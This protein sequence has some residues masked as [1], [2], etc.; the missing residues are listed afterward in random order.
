MTGNPIFHST[1]LLFSRPEK[2]LA[3]SIQ[4]LMEL[5]FLSYRVASEHSKCSPSTGSG[6]QDVHEGVFW[7]DKGRNSGFETYQKPYL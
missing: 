2:D 4:Y 3:F 7:V 1:V 5:S 6:K